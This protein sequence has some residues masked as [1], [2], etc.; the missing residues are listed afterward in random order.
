MRA[1]QHRLL[2]PD[3]LLVS[4]MVV[5]AAMIRFVGLDFATHDFTAYVRPWSEY[6]ASHGFFLAMGDDFANYNAPYLYLLTGLTWLHTHTPLS[7]MTLVKTLS[8]V[9]DV[10]LAVYAARIVGLRWPDRRVT[11][12]AGIVVL[13]LPT[14]VL[15]GA[16]WGQCDSIYSAFTMAG[17]YYVLRD[18]LWLAMAFF[19]LAVSFKLQ[20]VF[21]FPVLI[22]LLLAGRVHVRHLLVIPAVY[23]GLAVPAWLCG[24][25]F[26]DLML[27]YAKQSGQYRLLGLNA[28][29]IYA[30]L[31]PTAADLAVFRRAGVLFAVAAVLL[32]A[33]IALIR[34]G[35]LDP[36][37]IVLTAAA[38]SLL[39]PFLL[40]GMHERYF[41]QADVLAVVAA[42]W[43]PRLRLVPILVQVASFLSYVPYLQ[44]W[45]QPRPVDMRLL[46]LA[47]F[48]AL[49]LVIRE[50]LRG[51]PAVPE[52]GPEPAD[53]LAPKPVGNTIDG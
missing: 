8:V 6:I 46:A 34:G 31:H 10:V 36:A 50:L 52:P 29:T 11:A 13:L 53:A 25:P 5:V 26:T 16:F 20:A 21:V 1:F 38:S 51:G 23:I 2:H 24:R 40:P 15:N 30:F 28:P 35:T 18:R 39:T 47:M 12:L 43:V 22:V 7:V 45:R 33:Y 41:M 49:V 48:A 42:F 9:F 27:V 4:A 44:G 17:L 19:G 3:H 32:L 37:R 14:V